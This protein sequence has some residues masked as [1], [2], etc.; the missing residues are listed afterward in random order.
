ML[1]PGQGEDPG[2]EIVIPVFDASSVVG[3]HSSL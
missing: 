2:F 3:L 1:F